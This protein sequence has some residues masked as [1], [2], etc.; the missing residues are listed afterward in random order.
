MDINIYKYDI[1]KII[2][3]NFFSKGIIGIVSL[4]IMKYMAY[5]EYA[6]FTYFLSISSILIGIFVTSIN[7][8]FIVKHKSLNL[9]GEEYNLAIIQVIFVISMIILLQLMYSMK[10]NIFIALSILCVVICLSEFA[11]TYYQQ[12][13]IFSKYIMI[14][15]SR[16]MC[17]LILILGYLFLYSFEL[18][19]ISVIFLNAISYIVGIIFNINFQYIEKCKCDIKQ[20]QNIVYKLFNGQSK[21]LFLYN[22]LLAVLAQLNIFIIRNYGTAEQLASYGVAFQ[23]YNIFIL[24]LSAISVVFFPGVQKIQNQ[25]E[26]KLFFSFLRK[27]VGIMSVFIIICDFFI[28]NFM[29]WYFRGRY[30]SAIDVFIVFSIL[31]GFSVA[32]SP[33]MSI[34]MKFA[35]FKEVFYVTLIII[36]IYIITCCHVF[37]EFDIFGLSIMFLCSY[38]SLNLWGYFKEKKLLEKYDR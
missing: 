27:V 12:K 17:Y 32:L 24:I 4:L 16:N 5:N 9:E 6:D 30:E 38:T 3:S 28:I 26:I 31:S 10:L 22:A 2:I 19:A 18:L 8:I 14:E 36:I 20:L 23:F 1:V 21:Y 13:M 35:R 11:K 34:V 33:Y 29:D 37:F 15:I 7:G 25:H